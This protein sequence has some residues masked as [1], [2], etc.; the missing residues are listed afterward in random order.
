MNLI[1]IIKG[2]KL[3]FYIH[4]Y[5]HIPTEIKI[6][7]THKCNLRCKH[8]YWYGED[9][10]PISKGEKELSYEKIIKFLTSVNKKYRKKILISFTGGEIFL[11]KDVINIIEFVKTKGFPLRL[12]TNATLLTPSITKKLVELNVDEICISIDGDKKIHDKIRGKGVFDKVIKTLNNINQYKR[13][14]TRITFWCTITEDGVNGLEKTAELALKYN[15]SIVYLQNIFFRKI[16][17]I[18]VRILNEKM[19]FIRNYAKKNKLNAFFYNCDDAKNLSTWYSNKPFVGRCG[20]VK[21]MRI[22]PDGSVTHCR[23]KNKSFGNIKNK[24]F[25]DVWLSNEY[26]NFR[27]KYF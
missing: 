15:A 6:E 12:I 26:I 27:K 16:P 14:K 25:E 17:K 1:K 2:L 3:L 20:A 9:T 8:C 23:F 18:N 24:T 11:R 19:L 10:S 5:S 22:K 13:K 7:L 21:V 4:F